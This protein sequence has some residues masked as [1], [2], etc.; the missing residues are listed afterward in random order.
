MPEKFLNKIDERFA[1]LQQRMNGD[2]NG[3]IHRLRRNALEIFREKGLPTT[4]HEEWK[5]TNLAFLYK[6]DYSLEVEH[7]GTTDSLPPE[8]L[9]PGLDADLVVILNGRFSEE[10]SQIGGQ[11]GIEIES[12]ASALAADKTAAEHFGRYAETDGNPLTAINT[13]IAADGVYINIA[14]GAVAEK[15][16]HILNINNAENTPVFSQSRNLIIAG[17]NSS[18]RII[19]SHHTIGGEFSAF[20]HVSEIKLSQAA[21]LEHYKIQ[22]DKPDSHYI[23][24]VQAHQERDSVFSDYTYSIDGAFVRNDTNSVIGGQGCT[25]DYTGFYYCDDNNFVD[26]HTMADHARPNSMSN[27]NYR[28]ILNGRGTAV[29]NGKIMVRPDAQKTEAYQSNKNILLS[30]R[31]TINTKPQLEI[32]AD[33]VK[34]SHGATS[35]SIDKDQLFYLKSRGIGEEKAIALLLRAFANEIID[36]VKI[37]ELK[38]HLHTLI[39]KRLH[40]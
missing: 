39:T 29:F 36:K 30:D 31:A 8:F 27:E 22:N 3:D 34:C 19:A 21:N 14:R 9:V 11:K 23:G 1:K 20:N 6:H 2:R 18:A 38:L 40:Y 15:P 24:R 28:G 35:G 25:A 33:D 4:K 12:L 5:Y 26:N 10:L 32:F 16:I 13:A 7:P 37:P 17:E